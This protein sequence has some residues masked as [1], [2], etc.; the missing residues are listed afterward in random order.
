LKSS[1][2]NVNQFILFSSLTAGIMSNR[3]PNA[4]I[5][6]RSTSEYYLSETLL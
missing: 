1:L 5:T 4:Y 3:S 2:S 6:R